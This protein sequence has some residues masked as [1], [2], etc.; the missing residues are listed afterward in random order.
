[1]FRFCPVCRRAFS[2]SRARHLP[3]PDLGSVR[4]RA[5]DNLLVA[6][7]A[8]AVGELR[9]NTSLIAEDTSHVRR[10]R[11]RRAPIAIGVLAGVVLLATLNILPVM[12][13]ALIGVG[14]VLITGCIDPEEAWRSIDGSVLV[15]IFAMLGIGSG[16]E[17][18]G[19]V[20]M[21]MAVASPWLDVLPPLGLLLVL[22]FLTSLL[23]ESVTN[24]AVAVIMTPVVI[25]IGEATGSDVRALLIVVMFAASASFATP[26]GYQTNTMVCAAAD[27]RFT[28]FLK[29]GVVMN[30]VVGLA[31]CAAIAW[32]FL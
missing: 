4:L 30:L 5:A 6:A 29:I 15:L 19:T 26:I 31:T 17:R 9:K 7:G 13:L 8:D 22:Y 11:R 27:Y 23:T 12:T 14:V 3:G 10:F 16:L 24:D 25:G 1:M 32:L 18:V 20:D 21:I 28:D 2:A